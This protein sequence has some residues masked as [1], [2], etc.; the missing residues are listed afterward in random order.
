MGHPATALSF[1][2]SY[3]FSI[4]MEDHSFFSTR[5]LTSS[6]IEIIYVEEGA[7]VFIAGDERTSFT[8][9]DVVM[10][11]T[12]LC[13]QY[14]LDPAYVGEMRDRVRVSV[15]RF[16][17]DFWGETFLNLYENGHIKVLLD[18]ANRGIMPGADVRGTI[19]SLMERMHSSESAG[20]IILLLEIL[21]RIS[22]SKGIRSLSSGEDGLHPDEADRL[23]RVHQFSKENFSRKIGLGE[24]AA[25]AY[26]SPNSFCRWFKNRTRKTF[27]RYLIE[28]RVR[29]A[30][31]LLIE[32][33]L[34]S[35]RICI[36]SG[37][38]N[39]SNFH[40]C[41]KEVMGK[42]PIE[43]QREVRGGLR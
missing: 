36:E 23:E 3:S 2:T 11:G 5:P 14:K 15:I 34:C 41:F 24:I 42:S 20:K 30:C 9:G 17:P 25:V 28:L 16:L 38:N 7:G 35:K 18:S 10:T 21:F 6:R 22:V 13:C 37:F 39:F 40:K 19:Q 43:Y 1:Q 26:V 4:T 8:S 29:H 27:S 12:H 31:H 32:S 33:K